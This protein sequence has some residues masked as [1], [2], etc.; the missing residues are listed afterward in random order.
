MRLIWVLGAFFLSAN[1][2]F[3]AQFCTQDST[4]ELP[5]RDL[6]LTF[7]QPL[8]FSAD[9]SEVKLVWDRANHIYCSLGVHK[10]SKDALVIIPAGLTAK[11]D[12]FTTP[13]RFDELRGIFFAT[14]TEDLVGYLHCNLSKGSQGNVKI[15]E[16]AHA[17]QPYLKFNLDLK[18]CR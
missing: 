15:G 5:K 6:E 4:S 14:G 8:V 11:M 17:L 1:V 2:A 3:S 7:T 12:T 13:E 18:D 16:L 9:V 10:I